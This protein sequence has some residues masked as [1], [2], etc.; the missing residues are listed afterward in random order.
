LQ[1]QAAYHVDRVIRMAV[2]QGWVA[3]ID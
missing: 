2:L 1:R 3:V